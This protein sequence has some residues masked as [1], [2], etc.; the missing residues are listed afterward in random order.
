MANVRTKGENFYR[1]AKRVK[2]LNV[3]KEGKAQ[4]NA[5]GVITKAASYQSKDVPT[6]VIEPNRKWFTNTRVISQDTLTAFREA[7]AET[8]KDPYKVLLKVCG[9]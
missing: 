5:D 8:E 3:L 2:Q 1:T 6:A 9:L 4:R 7:V